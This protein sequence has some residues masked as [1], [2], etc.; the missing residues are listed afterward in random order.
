MGDNEVEF[1][2]EA[3]AA[4][5]GSGPL[6]VEDVA[7][8]AEAPLLGSAGSDSIVNAGDDIVAD[9]LMM[10]ASLSA[11]EMVAPEVVAPEVAPE[12]PVGPSM[13]VAP[14]SPEDTSSGNSKGSVSHG[15]VPEP[16]VLAAVPRRSQ[17]IAARAVKTEIIKVEAPQTLR[18]SL[19]IAALVKKEYKI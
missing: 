2:A 9:A 13:A 7:A 5:H 11:P 6:A 4:L 8:A 18:R 19:R 14:P 1:A 10:L 15:A 12:D 3:L 17:R 16:E